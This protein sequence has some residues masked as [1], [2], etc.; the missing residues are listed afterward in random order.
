VICYH[1]V[2]RLNED[3]IVRVNFRQDDATAHT[4]RVSMPP[5]RDVFGDRII[6]KDIWP[7]RSPDFITPPDDYL[8]GETKGAV[9]K[10]NPH[11]SHKLKKAIENFVKNIPLTE[12][13]RV[14]GNNIRNV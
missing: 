9:Y 10:H 1:F 13:S 3:E 8:C 12:L 14:F 4:A 11:I 6:S 2:G 7:P 5:L